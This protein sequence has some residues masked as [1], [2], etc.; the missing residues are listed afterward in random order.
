MESV[1]IFGPRGKGRT[2]TEAEWLASDDLLLVLE[3]LE[4]WAADEEVSDRKLRLF[5][6]ACCRR[7]WHLLTDETRQHT[8]ELA[9]R[10]AD[11]EATEE[12][13][14]DRRRMTFLGTEQDRGNEPVVVRCCLMQGDIRG[15]TYDYLMKILHEL[16]K[17]TVKPHLT[18][19]GAAEAFLCRDIFGNPFNPVSFDPSWLTS[20][21]TALAQQMYDSRDFS[22]MPILADALQDANCDDPQILE[23]CRGLGPHVR[24]CWVCDL[25][26][27]KS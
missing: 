20:T 16:L 21:V 8:V 18:E 6:C 9:E 1:R 13:I 5:A 12:E 23:H 11:G 3:T 25:C 24:G 22:A 7:M 27:N 19:E 14:I 26:L 10:Y 4:P 17:P 15:D 2:V